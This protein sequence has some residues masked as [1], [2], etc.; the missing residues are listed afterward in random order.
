M[1]INMRYVIGYSRLMI[2]V[3]GNWR[4]TFAFEDDDAYIVNHEDYQ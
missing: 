3:S 2:K 1:L 4:L